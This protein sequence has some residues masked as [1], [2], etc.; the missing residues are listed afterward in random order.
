MR[1]TESQR[2]R[3]HSAQILLSRWLSTTLL[4]TV[5]AGELPTVCSMTELT[6]RKGDNLKSPEYSFN[7][8]RDCG[9][10]HRACTGVSQMGY[11]S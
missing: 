5:R 7:D 2:V 9:R 3:R 4:R 1:F 10:M 11:Q 8:L 6:I